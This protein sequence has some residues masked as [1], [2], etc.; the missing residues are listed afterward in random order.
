MNTIHSVLFFI[1]IIVGS[2]ALLLFWV[3]IVTKKGGLDHRKFGR[4]YANTMYAVAA[5]GALMA[6]MVIYA[7]L[8][9][10]HQLVHEN[11][12]TQQLASTLRIFWSFLLYL[13][14]LTFVN[15]RH[16]ILVL[17][18][19]T[20]H[21]NMRQLPHLFSI[22]LLFIGGLIL[23][24]F[25]LI[26]SNTLH[27]IFGVLGAVLAIQTGR[28]CLANSVSA[29]RWLVEH[30]SA[31]IGSGIAAYTAFLAFGGRSMFGDLGPFQL[32]FWVAP[33]VIGTIAIARM[34]RKYK[35]GLAAKKLI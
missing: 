30:L 12:N 28:F 11:T 5:S 34:S 32:V 35:E 20:Q 27:I 19:K 31:F 24:L 9:I 13:S 17:R 16:G 23:L 3:P 22:G 29:N 7:P 18:N 6:L 33:G 21:S 4:Y 25:G 10:K 26:Y 14:L 15:V 2:M 1:H 8:V